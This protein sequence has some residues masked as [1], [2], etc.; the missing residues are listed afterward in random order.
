M[1]KKKEYEIFCDAR[2][3]SNYYKGEILPFVN[4]MCRKD[5]TSGDIDGFVW[6][7]EK[8]IYIVLEQKWVYERHNK[9]QDDHLK[10]IS[11]ILQKAK[12][13]DR[14]KD[15]YFGVYKLVGNPP[16][17]SILITDMKTNVNKKLN[18]NQLKDFLELNKTFEQF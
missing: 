1:D 2:S 16:F 15:Y 4:K 17:D 18:Q 14:F 9:R 11:C 7:F 13:D 6:D 3:K 5:M 10:F 12:Q 8:K